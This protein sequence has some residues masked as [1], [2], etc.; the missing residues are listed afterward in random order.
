MK[1]KFPFRLG[2]TSYILRDDILPNV[3][4][5]KDQVDHIELLVFETDDDSNYP[6]PAMVEELNTIATDHD[7]T[8]TVHLPLDIKLGTPDEALRRKNV[9]LTLRAIDA[10]RPLN[11]LAWDLHLERNDVLI[12]EDAAWQ[13]ACARS[14]NELKAGGA[15]PTRIGVETLEF[16]FANTVPVLDETGFAVTL[17]IGHIWYCGFDEAHY[18]ENI[19]PRAVSF[20]LHGFNEERDHK[21]LRNIPPEQLKRFLDAVAARPNAAQLP[22]SIEVFSETQFHPSMEVMNELA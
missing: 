18:L 12:P 3:H 16:D 21:S 14:L 13:A 19:L 7:L 5:L 10:T 4:F 17:D 1:N 15:D 6:S 8:Y 2:T 22:I 9:E 11:P 20:H